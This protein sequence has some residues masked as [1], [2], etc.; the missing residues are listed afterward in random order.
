MVT[1]KPRAGQH[2][3]CL[4]ERES[5]S[6]EQAGVWGEALGATRERGRQCESPN[7]G[8]FILLGPQK[9]PDTDWPAGEEKGDSQGLLKVEVAW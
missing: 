3:N 4:S 5:R 7:R 8:S 1:K 9:A 6:W 2:L